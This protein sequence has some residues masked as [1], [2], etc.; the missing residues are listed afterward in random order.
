MVSP[1]LVLLIIL[2]MQNYKSYLICNLLLLLGDESRRIEAQ[3]L[4]KTKS[5]IENVLRNMYG[6]DAPDATDI[7]VSGWTQNPLTKGSFTNWPVDVSSECYLNLESRVDRVFFGGEA[8]SYVYYGYIAGAL[9]SGEREARKILGCM[10]NFED[11]PIFEGAGLECG[12]RDLDT[13]SANTL[14]CQ[15]FLVG[16]LGAMFLTN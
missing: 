12:A 14:Y 16:T 3:P 15:V 8:T 11:C 9:E 4:S 13:N 10:D 5:E 7:L 6:D 1:Q 2:T